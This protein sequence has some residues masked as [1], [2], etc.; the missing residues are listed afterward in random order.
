MIFTILYFSQALILYL[1]HCLIHK[2]PTCTNVSDTLSTIYLSVTNLASGYSQLDWNSVLT[3][4]NNGWYTLYREY[5]AGNIIAVIT[6]PNGFTFSDTVNVCKN[7]TAKYIVTLAD[8]SGCLHSSS[9]AIL[10]N[11]ILQP[12]LTTVD[13]V[14]VDPSLGNAMISWTNGNSIDVSG[15]IIYLSNPS[16]GWD[17][18]T[19]VYG[20]NNTYYLNSGSTAGSGS[21]SYSIAAID[22]CGNTSPI[23]QGHS[24][25]FVMAS[26]DRCSA[27]I[28]VTWNG[29][30]GW[31]G[32]TPTYSVYCTVNGNDSLLNVTSG[33]SFVHSG[34]TQN[35]VY[36]YYIRASDG[37]GRTSTSN[38]YCIAAD[39]IQLPSFTYLNNITVQT[40]GS[41]FISC[42][43]DSSADVDYY[44]VQRSEDSI[45]FETIK[46]IDD[47]AVN[48]R[49]TFTDKTASATDAIIYYRV[50]VVDSCGTESF[51]SN[52]AKTIY[53]RAEVKSDIRN[54]L[55]WNQYRS[56]ISP[57]SLYNV[58]R[59]VNDA[60][61]L[62]PV[63]TKIPQYDPDSI[64]DD[65]YPFID[66]RGNFCYYVQAVQ[67]P[68]TNPY[69]SGPAQFSET[70]LSNIV[71]VDQ[72][73]K[74]LIPN[75]FT[76][77][78]DG[79]NDFFMPDRA[80]IDA[81]D[82]LLIIYNRYGQEIFSTSNPDEAWDGSFR[83]R[84]IQSGAYVYYIR[85]KLT[86]G[87]IIEK[88]GTVTL[89]R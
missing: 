53:L 48:S 54:L 5:P 75:T 78:G 29:Y 87:D 65:V 14:S 20:I 44:K 9:V 23:S 28:S 11:D 36:C 77:N 7:D 89:L 41:V 31:N 45:F 27:T 22:A 17:S 32:F 46:T 88:S 79:V 76:P 25:M 69:S 58:Y 21:E 34:L 38:R 55:V 57:V 74:L 60:W 73:Q 26:S 35:Q 83:T 12:G 81:G 37:Y 33:T 39:I 50:V 3:G 64:N 59:K 49:I 13:S 61:E 86:N 70:S 67:S 8:S 71:C 80:F 15:Y 52:V 84:Q 68:V 19:T 56:W 40:D 42:Y 63:N 4:T 18:I 62:S 66:R 10:T 1:P 85:F 2:Y 82:Y 24:T 72:F 16:G 43:T 30:N 51:I 47:Q 6:V